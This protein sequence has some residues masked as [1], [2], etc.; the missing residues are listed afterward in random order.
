MARI[1]ITTPHEGGPFTYT[2]LLE[3]ELSRRGIS[4]VIRSFGEVL[5]LP[6]VIRHVVFFFKLVKSSL[7]ARVL[8]AQDPVSTG[9]PTLL[10]ARLTGKIFVLRIAGDYAWEQGQQFFDVTDTIGMFQDK[11]Y[12]GRVE[13]LRRIQRFVARHANQVIVPS[14]YFASVVRTWG[15]VDPVVI[16]NGIKLGVMPQEPPVSVP[17]KTIVSVGRLVPWKGFDM[18]VTLM[19]QFPEWHLILVG[20]G[21]LRLALEQHAADIGVGDRVQFTGSLSREE[22]YGLFQKAEVFVLNT[23]FESFS[24]LAVEAMDAGIPVVA[25]RT[26]SIPEVIRDG[27][28]GVLVEPSNSD[29]IRKAIEKIASEKKFRSALIISGKER[30]KEFTIAKTTDA[31]IA[32]TRYFV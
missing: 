19:K 20:D 14:D 26:G 17:P 27:I 22:I 11:I 25:G 3:E 2:K 21:E 16:Y 6:K 15:G 30:A 24:F 10:A 9:L 18:L 12:S 28:D 7:G 29:D 23:S 32:L 1:V 31:F 13:I 5:Y 8:Y 4:V